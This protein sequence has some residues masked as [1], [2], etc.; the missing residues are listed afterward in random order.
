MERT[1]TVKGVGKASARPDL[2]VIPLSLCAEA[3]EYDAAAA[4]AERQL[5]ALRAVLAPLGFAKDDLPTV[6]Y[7][8]ATNYESQ[9]DEHGIYRSHFVGYRCSH[10]LR[11]EF[12]LDTERLSAVLAA[13]SGCEAKPEFSV[14][15]TVRDPDALYAELLRSAAENARGK[16]EAL[17]AASGVQLGEL[18]HVRYS[19]DEVNVISSSRVMLA[20]DAA[21]RAKGLDITP[22]DVKSSDT[23][24]FIWAIQ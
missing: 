20:C 3:E 15:F 23:V 1:I 19:W 14:R 24:T 6:N 11:L 5:E 2:I 22:E 17:C 10:E 9:P 12:P 4:L 18:L 21:P 8:V 7:E 16:A 13:L